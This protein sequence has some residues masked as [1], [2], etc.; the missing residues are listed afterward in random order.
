M[1]RAPK[2][3]RQVLK[4]VHDLAVARGAKDAARLLGVSPSYVYK[5]S[6]A[7]R[8]GQPA[9]KFIRSKDTLSAWRER[10]SYAI[11]EHRADVAYSKAVRL[12]E[13]L[14]PS[15]IG[16]AADVSYQ[17]ATAALREIIGKGGKA[18]P[19][20]LDIIN[21]A[22]RDFA[23]AVE[24]REVEGVL[25]FPSE[26]ALRTAF[27]EYEKRKL[28]PFLEDA[29]AYLSKIA[30]KAYFVIVEYEHPDTGEVAYIPTYIPELG[31]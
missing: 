15:E 8:E 13:Y 11:E 5:I 25:V 7:Y 12:A 23:K 31:A 16:R 20:Y 30:G 3:S 19:E 29:I 18:R 14:S 27:K 21:R 26:R 28:A 6:K 1:P 4:I 24:P 2:G 22:Y 9:Y 10:V 17:K